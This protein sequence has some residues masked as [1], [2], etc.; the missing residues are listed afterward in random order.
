M[1]SQLLVALLSAATLSSGH[2]VQQS[3]G[4]ARRAVNLNNFRLK[5]T[6]KYINSTSTSTD[7]TATVVKRATPVDTA[8]ELVKKLFPDATF[9]VADDSYVGTNGIAHVYFKQTAHG[10]DIDN[11]DFNVNVGYTLFIGKISGTNN[12]RLVPTERCSP[13]A[14][15]SLLA[16]SLPP[17]R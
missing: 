17:T 16:P 10:I 15:I 4:V 6:S 2:P 1:R 7:F 3:S 5:N 13:M 11:S 9:R 8:T 12:N 14:T